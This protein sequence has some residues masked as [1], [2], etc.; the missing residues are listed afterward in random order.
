MPVHA[1]RAIHAPLEHNERTRF[2]IPGGAVEDGLAVDKCLRNAVVPQ[3]YP[4]CIVGGQV[5]LYYK[6]VPGTNSRKR[7]AP[8]VDVRSIHTVLHVEHAVI[9]SAQD[10][11][12]ALASRAV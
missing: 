12:G 3:S 8:E 4:A 11:R 6:R 2:L 7:Y 1:A 10:Q 9:Y 5:D